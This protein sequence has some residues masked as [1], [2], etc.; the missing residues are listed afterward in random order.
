M[1]Y[2]IV[3][4]T[5]VMPSKS[6]QPLKF[7]SVSALE[8]RVTLKRP[9]PETTVSFNALILQCCDFYCVQT[10]HYLPI[11]PPFPKKKQSKPRL[12]SEA[13]LDRRKPIR[14][15]NESRNCYVKMHRD[16]HGR[17]TCT[18]HTE[19]NSAAFFP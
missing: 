14:N 12:L 1:Y 19:R 7:V 2:F 17:I 18:R 3:S 9:S 4:P 13:I 15:S 5:R 8:N 16:L 6:L 11:R 10:K